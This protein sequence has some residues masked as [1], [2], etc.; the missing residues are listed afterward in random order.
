MA[1]YLDLAQLPHFN[2]GV[3]I[4]TG[5]TIDSEVTWWQAPFE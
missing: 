1:R 2:L 3:V 4:W 5:I